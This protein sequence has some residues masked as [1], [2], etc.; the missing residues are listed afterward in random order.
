M[1]G[2]K[3]APEIEAQDARDGEYLQEWEYRTLAIIGVVNFD[4]TLNE[5]AARGWELV[6]GNMA[7]TTHYGYLRRRLTRP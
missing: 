6:N 2:G 5:H 4:K 7:G 3:K 1:F